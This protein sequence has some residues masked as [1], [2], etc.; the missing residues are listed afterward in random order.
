[1]PSLLPASWA[2]WLGREWWPRR[3]PRPD[4][5]NLHSNRELNS[6]DS[7]EGDHREL[8][9]WTQLNDK[10]PSRW[11]K[12]AEDQSQTVRHHNGGEVGECPMLLD[13]EADAEATA[14]GMPAARKAEAEAADW[15]LG[16]SGGNAALPAPS[17]SPLRPALNV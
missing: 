3:C 10:G 9:L 6:R 8:S 16:P 15:H 7:G 5:E 1:M 13:A 17:R 12:E 4:P 2:A 11:R 14:R